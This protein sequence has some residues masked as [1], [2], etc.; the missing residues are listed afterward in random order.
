MPTWVC[1]CGDEMGAIYYTTK[2]NRDRENNTP[3]LISFDANLRDVIIDG[4]DFLYRLGAGLGSQSAPA[5]WIAKQNGSLV[6]PTAHRPRLKSALVA[7]S[8]QGESF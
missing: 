6:R 2:H 4:R 1:A 3:V 7:G 5:R 8:S